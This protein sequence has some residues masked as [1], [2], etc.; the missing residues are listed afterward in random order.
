MVQHTINVQDKEIVNGLT[1]DLT[2][3]VKDKG[4]H[5]TFTNSKER[6]RDNK[7]P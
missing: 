6:K 3:M 1:E 2:D 5:Y 4:D 7:P